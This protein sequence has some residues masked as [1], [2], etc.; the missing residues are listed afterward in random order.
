MSNSIGRTLFHQIQQ[1]GAFADFG[2]DVEVEVEVEVEAESDP[3]YEEEPT[4]IVPV[5][6]V[7]PPSRSLRPIRTGTLLRRGVSSVRPSTAGGY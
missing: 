2:A 1:Q 3:D 7:L 6:T 4:G 5:S